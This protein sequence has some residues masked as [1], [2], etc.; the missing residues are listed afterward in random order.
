MQLPSQ[1]A[2]NKSAPSDLIAD[3]NSPATVADTSAAT[4]KLKGKRA[5]SE[6]RV[7]HCDIIK[8]EFWDARPEM[9]AA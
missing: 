7:L 9:L 4:P 2:P 8:N 5:K 3:A 6:I 1:P